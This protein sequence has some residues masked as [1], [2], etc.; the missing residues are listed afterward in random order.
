MQIILI[1]LG[2]FHLNLAIS[3]FNDQNYGL[4]SYQ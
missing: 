3:T 1:E 4:Q 2:I